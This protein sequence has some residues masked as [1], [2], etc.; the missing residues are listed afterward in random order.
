[1]LAHEFLDSVLLLALTPNK[2]DGLTEVFLQIET[3]AVIWDTG[4][5]YYARSVNTLVRRSW[6]TAADDR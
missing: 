2:N 3:D 4:M 5:R 6:V 1:M